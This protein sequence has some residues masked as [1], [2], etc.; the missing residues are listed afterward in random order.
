MNFKTVEYVMTQFKV[1]TNFYIIKAGFL[2]KWK[3][4]LNNVKICSKFQLKKPGTLTSYVILQL[5]RWKIRRAWL[6]D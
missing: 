2:C 3:L 1:A 5:G 4:V 6:I